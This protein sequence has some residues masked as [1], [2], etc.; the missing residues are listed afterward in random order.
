MPVSGSERADAHR[1][2]SRLPRELAQQLLDEP[3]ARLEAGTIRISPLV[4]LV[5]SANAALLSSQ[6]AIATGWDRSDSGR[7]PLGRFMLHRNNRLLDLYQTPG[8]NP[9]MHGVMLRA[10]IGPQ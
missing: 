9:A 5:R 2:L 7:K 3:A 8:P 10:V 6:G 1:R 4:Y